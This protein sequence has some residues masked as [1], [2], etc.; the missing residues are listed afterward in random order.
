MRAIISDIEG[1]PR[2]IVSY[3]P[4]GWVSGIVTKRAAWVTPARPGAVNVK[5]WNGP[6]A[7]LPAHWSEQDLPDP[8]LQYIVRSHLHMAGWLRVMALGVTTKKAYITGDSPSGRRW[9]I[10]G[11]QAN[12]LPEKEIRLACEDEEVVLGTD[13]EELTE[14]LREEQKGGAR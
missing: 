12:T 5:S 1:F 14:W 8:T 10:T 2:P 9:T 7:V 11:R 4:T 6:G 13:L 3:L